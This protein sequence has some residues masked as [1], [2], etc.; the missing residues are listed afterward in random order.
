MI[1]C[2]SR[3]FSVEGRE[4]LVNRFRGRQGLFSVKNVE[5]FSEV[6]A[7]SFHLV[8]LEVV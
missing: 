5:F 8:D 4:S 2:K 6:L 1:L 7:F 3:K